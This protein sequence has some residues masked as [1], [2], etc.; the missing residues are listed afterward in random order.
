MTEYEPDRYSGQLLS[1]TDPNGNVTSYA[2]D[3][4]N[5]VLTVTNPDK[6]TVTYEYDDKN[7]NITASD[8]NGEQVKYSYTPI[9][10]SERDQLSKRRH[11][12]K[13]K[14]LRSI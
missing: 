8:E 6:T 1:Q 13:K 7:N 3:R 2:Y 14:D 12:G 11:H 10:K 5:R 9:G 4:L